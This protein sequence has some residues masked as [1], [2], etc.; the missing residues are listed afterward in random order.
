MKSTVDYR[1]GL[2]Q[3]RLSLAVIGALAFLFC[4]STTSAFGQDEGDLAQPQESKLWEWDENDP[5]IGLE[6]GLHDAGQ[7]AWNVELLANLPKPEGFASEEDTGG[8]VSNTDLAFSGDLAFVG[9][10]RG[11]NAYDV[12]DPQNPTLRVSVV[13]P[14]G[15]GDVSVY[16]NLLFMSV[17]ETR[18]RLDCGTEGVEEP[19]SD[20]RFRGVRIFDISD[21]DT[22]RQVAAVQTCRGSH[23]HSLVSDPNDDSHIYVYVS[24]TSPVRPGEELEGCSGGDRRDPDV[25]PS[26]SYFR[27]EV[28]E[29]PLRNPEM[30]KVVNEPRVFEVDGNIAGLWQGGDHG[31]GTQQSRRTTQ[32]HD[33][34]AYPEIGLAGGACAGNGILFD[35]SDP[36]NPVR[37]DEVTDP[38]F[39]YW[40]SATFNNDGTKVIFTDEW[41]GGGQPRCR[42]T[43]LPSWGAN[44][45][46]DIVDGKELKLRG[47]YKL[48]VPQSEQENCVAHNGSLIPI[49]GRDIKAQAWY[50]GGMSVFDFT[51]PENPVE[52]AFFDRGPIDGEE[53]VSGGYWSTYWFNGQIYGAEI[54]RGF[55]IFELTPSEHLSQNEIDAAKLVSIR[56]VN[57]QNQDKLSW[58]AEFVVARAYTD[59][60]ER[61]GAFSA[62]K[63]SEVMTTLN[64]AERQTAGAGKRSAR[65]QL[66]A[67]AAE[68]EAYALAS[69]ADGGAKGSDRTRVLLARTLRDLANEMR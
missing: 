37:L 60:L 12:S 29:V 21:I 22:P 14:G 19:V 6:P 50:Q 5:R 67:M 39:A 43:D 15:Q 3:A 31:P 1:A 53:L 28:I 16:Q 48:P 57:A 9:N 38:N 63:A 47:Y 23:T 32:C 66:D 54:A 51:D 68:L 10:Y 2:T 11:W 49:P 65:L 46:F 61:S 27:I 4:F 42:E 35:I 36:S 17:Q 45:I 41:G 58:P 25:D 18:G 40:H 62:G 52:I 24:G 64:N 69:L 7:A 56:D 33:I 55:D 30:S 44:A 13:C 26:S 20:E 59:Q 8:R 34:T